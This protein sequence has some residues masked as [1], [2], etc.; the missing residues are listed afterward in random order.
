MNDFKNFFVRDFPFGDDPDEDVLD[1]DISKAQVEA[2]FNFNDGLFSSQEFFDLGFNY[3][4]AHYLVMDLRASS[5][6]IAGQ[7]SWNQ[8]GR[9]V[10]SVSESIQIPQQILDNPNYSFLTKTNY[11]AKFLSLILPQLIGQ[12]FVVCGSTRP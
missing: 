2:K 4:T 5:Q 6:G 11:G 10:G 12:V 3:L 9:S 1:V 8:T 7:W